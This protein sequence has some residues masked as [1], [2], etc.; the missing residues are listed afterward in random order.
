[1]TDD[2]PS[3]DDPS[4]SPPPDD[5][6]DS[7]P[8]ADDGRDTDL[9]PGDGPST[10]PTASPSDLER[11]LSVLE[12]AVESERV[13]ESRLERLLA[14]LE[15]V[16][17]TPAGAD[18]ETVAEFLSLLE[19]A[20]ADAGR[21]NEVDVDGLL[22]VLETAAAAVPS[23]DETAAEEVLGVLERGL[24]DPNSLEQ[25][26]IETLNE[27]I[28]R[29]VAE[30][31][32][33]TAG[34]IDRLF[35]ESGPT[36]GVTN[37]FRIA[38][39][40]TAMTQRATGHA[41]ES[42]LRTGTRM[43]YAA[44]TAESP[45]ALL[46]EARAVALDELR[47]S[48]VDIGDERQAWLEAH[49]DALI[50]DRPVTEEQLRARG[51]RLLSKSATLGRPEG[52]HP[53]FGAI[54]DQLAE[55]EARILRLL[56]T[57]GAQPTVDIYE[58]GY[59]PFNARLVAAALTKLGSDAGCRTPKRVPLYVQ[60]LDRLGLVTLSEEPVENL[61]IYQVLEAQPHVEQARQGVTR[62]KADYGSIRLTELGAAFCEACFPVDVADSPPATELRRD[63]AE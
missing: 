38:H 11:A 19:D 62:P 36:E 53:A 17:A 18:P 21:L 42:G 23:V 34:G 12:T 40:V 29:L 52:P 2:Q 50:A 14:A 22:S 43:G 27:Q 56:A 15:R 3:D 25:T 61:K 35:P 39:I 33:P 28:E 45:A 57:D 55:D 32:D 30:A 41:V 47:R 48:G 51:E 20:L 54:I 44:A 10:T 60:N 5:H 58:R 1:M 46:T 13:G 16:V 8:P 6:P 31:T 9:P 7:G 37:A 24:R 49:E 26:D 59:I 4:S 63:G